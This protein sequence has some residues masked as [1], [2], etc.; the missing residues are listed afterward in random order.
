M[1]FHFLLVLF[2]ADSDVSLDNKTV[3]ESDNTIKEND[4]SDFYLVVKSDGGSIELHKL[5]DPY[6]H[7]KKQPLAIKYEKLDITGEDLKPT[8][9]ELKVESN[10]SGVTT[11]ATKSIEDLNINEDTLENEQSDE[12]FVTTYTFYPFNS[13]INYYHPQIKIHKQ[14]SENYREETPT[15]KPIIIHREMHPTKSPIQFAVDPDSL[16]DAYNQLRPTHLFTRIPM[17][18]LIVSI[19]NIILIISS[20]IMCFGDVCIYGVIDNDDAERPLDYVV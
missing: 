19:V 20:V 11:S 17:T 4:I 9:S 1:F 13:H 12:V 18:T 8:D 15:S 2:L 3:H 10:T 6:Y 5:F 16:Y 7:P 14:T